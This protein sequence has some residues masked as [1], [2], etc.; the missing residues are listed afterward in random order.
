MN[1]QTI[2]PEDLKPG[3][4]IVQHRE[5]NIFFLGE[6]NVGR[7]MEFIC[8]DGENS[9]GPIM[10]VRELGRDKITKVSIAHLNPPYST[11]RLAT[12][13]ERQTLDFVKMGYNVS[14]SGGVS[15]YRADDGSIR[16]RLEAAQPEPQ[17]Q[18]KSLE[19]WAKEA[20]EWA[21]YI[22]L[23]GDGSVW[24]FEYEPT[25]RESRYK[26]NYDY[27]DGGRF[28]S[29]LNNYSKQPLTSVTP[30]MIAIP[31]A[32][33]PE[34][35]YRAMAE[36]LEAQQD[37]L[38]ELLTSVREA[39]GAQDGDDVVAV[40]K[41][42]AA[43]ASEG[44]KNKSALERLT[45][46]ALEVRAILGVLAGED[47]RDGA[48]RVALLAQEAG[49]V[50]RLRSV[51]DA[52]RAVY[53]ALRAAAPEVCRPS[54]RDTA[55]AR[56]QHLVDGQFDLGKPDLKACERLYGIFKDGQRVREGGGANPHPAN[57]VA[58]L[59][60]SMGWV[61]RDLSMAL[62]DE[63][64]RRK[65]DG[66]KLSVGDI[67][68]TVPGDVSLHVVGDVAVVGA[69]H[70]H[71]P[72]HGGYPDQRGNEPDELAGAGAALGLHEPDPHGP[73]IDHYRV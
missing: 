8:F 5:F 23:D 1:N 11:M 27:Y 42:V 15:A 19:D 4:Y 60:H 37:A 65:A 3:Q 47:L 66:I 46:V 25:L 50:T 67:S 17:E 7:V 22:A 24:V 41:R 59:L 40:A 55:L 53:D 35:D 58:G 51:E 54:G 10:A 69:S 44:D 31:K 18:P 13:L 30:R 39:L 21:N 12:E 73:G 32:A 71:K 43:Q 57:S 52:W 29:L 48:Q 9:C 26:N 61:Q 34:K 64:R 38:L 2:K 56:V 70:T 36:E 49:N 14:I 28:K 68:L 45:S 6:T 33:E 63:R 20:P 72:V 62:D 16:L